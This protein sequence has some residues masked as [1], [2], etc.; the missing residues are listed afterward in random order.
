MKFFAGAFLEADGAAEVY[1]HF[2]SGDVFGV[3]DLRFADEADAEAGYGDGGGFGGEERECRATMLH[4]VR[5]F[6][7]WEGVDYDAANVVVTYPQ[8]FE[9]CD[10]RADLDFLV[11]AKEVT[12]KIGSPT[13]QRKIDR[14]LARDDVLGVVVFVLDAECERGGDFSV[15]DKFKESARTLHIKTWQWIVAK[16]LV[17]VDA[18]VSSLCISQKTDD[19][20]HKLLSASGQVLNFQTFLSVYHNLQVQFESHP[21]GKL[22]FQNRH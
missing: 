7:R 22:L 8:R 12:A 11:R 17:R 14:Q 18:V 6:C 20:L 9:L 3:D 10:L 1:D 4:M 19:Q 16:L 13:L 21:L 15:G 2:G 5:I